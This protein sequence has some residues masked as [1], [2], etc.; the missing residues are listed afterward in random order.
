[1]IQIIADA[2]YFSKI[3]GLIFILQHHEIFKKVY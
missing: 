1:M 2:I 3:E